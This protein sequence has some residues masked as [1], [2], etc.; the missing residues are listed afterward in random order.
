[1]QVKRAQHFNWALVLCLKLQIISCWNHSSVNLVDVYVLIPETQILM[2]SYSTHGA[3]EELNRAGV[4][5]SPK[6]V[7]SISVESLGLYAGY[8]KVG[9]TYK[10]IEVHVC[11]AMEVFTFLSQSTLIT[12]NYQVVI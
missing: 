8:T 4:Y 1:M 9:T 6:L 2:M 5:F 11:F 12:D 3:L 10:N 7:R